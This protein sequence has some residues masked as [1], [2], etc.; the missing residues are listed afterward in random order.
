MPEPSLIWQVIIRRPPKVILPVQHFTFNGGVD[1]RQQFANRVEMGTV[2]VTQ[3]EVEQ[4]VL[5]GMQANF[6]QLLLCAAPTPVREL[7]GTASNKR[8]DMVI[9][10]PPASSPTSQHRRLFRPAD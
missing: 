5:H 9:T 1:A 8:P 6:R 2:F 7:S 3:R 4:E 10:L